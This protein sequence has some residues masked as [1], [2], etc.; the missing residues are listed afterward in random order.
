MSTK[1]LLVFHT[2]MAPYRIDLWNSL[3]KAYNFKIY[4]LRDNLL[5]Q[6]FDQERLKQSVEFDTNYLTTGFRIGW[7]TFRVG[8]LKIIKRFNPDLVIS[9]EYSQTTW[10]LVLL[11]KIFGFKY[12]VFTICDD[13][14]R[15]AIDCHGGRKISRDLLVKQLD[16]L[17]LTNDEVVNW[18]KRQFPSVKSIVKFPIIIREDLFRDNLTLSIPTANQF[19]RDF[20]LEGKRIIFFVGRL[21]LVKGLDRLFHSLV[22]VFK[23][24]SNAILVIIGNGDEELNLRTLAKSLNIDSKVIFAGRCEGTPLNAWYNIGQLFVLP[25]H[26]EPFGAVVNEALIAGA[27]VGCS[28]YA[29]SASLIRSEVN[30]F[31]FDPYEMKDLSAKLLLQ[32]QQIEPIKFIDKIR[33]T[34][35]QI[36]Y[37][38]ALAPLLSICSN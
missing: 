26:Y 18:Y 30:G 6:K 33:N 12:K 31:V 10:T 9:Y 29:G 3:N 38:D 22:D 20:Q 13:S 11:K 5:N 21:V 2:A 34:K 25:S 17:I 23:S 27:F 24:D 19:I 14:L 32:L 36:K 16:G 1:K 4:F 35:M 37:E 7:R 8:F 15:I 28:S